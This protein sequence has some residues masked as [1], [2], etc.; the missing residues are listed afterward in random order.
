MSTPD[1]HFWF[2]LQHRVHQCGFATRERISWW[3]TNTSKTYVHT[4]MHIGTT[5]YVLY[6]EVEQPH[7]Q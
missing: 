1:M 5:L 3:M 7:G 6:S 4:Y 2:A